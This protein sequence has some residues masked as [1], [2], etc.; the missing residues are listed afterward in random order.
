MSLPAG[1]SVGQTAGVQTTF[2]VKNPVL[3]RSYGAGVAVQASAG[4][5]VV[6]SG[7]ADELT[8]A[9]AN[10]TILAGIL[11]HDVV[12]T[13]A[14]PARVKDNLFGVGLLGYNEVGQAASAWKMGSF[15]L[16]AVNGSVS[17]GD[18]VVPDANG[19]WKTGNA[20]NTLLNGAVICE[21]GNTV[22]GGPIEVSVNLA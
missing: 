14:L 17:Y 16:T 4:M 5:A 11:G 21:V 9:A 19:Y 7:N 22:A 13:S 20:T 2:A 18:F 3:Q 8:L 10:S 12:D 1:I 15:L 6:R